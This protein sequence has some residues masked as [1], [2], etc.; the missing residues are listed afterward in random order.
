MAHG[1][2]K[3]LSRAKTRNVQ[4]SEVILR[5]VIGVIC[6]ALAFFIP[7]VLRW[8]LALTGI[9]FLLTAFFGY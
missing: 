4:R 2:P 8:I 7:G 1:E 9:A 6:V 5:I 3:M